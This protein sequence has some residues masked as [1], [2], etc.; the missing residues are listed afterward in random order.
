LRTTAGSALALLLAGAFAAP[1]PAA[2]L[3]APG[4][5]AAREVVAVTAGGLQ[6]GKRWAVFIASGDFAG[7][8]CRAQLASRRAHAGEPTVFSGIVPARLR[9]QL[10]PTAAQVPAPDP[11]REFVPVEPGHPYQFVV[12]I[13]D[14]MFCRKAAVARQ[15]VHAVPTGRACAPLSFTPAS[16]NG[17]FSIRARN[18]GC[19][20][21]HKAARAAEGGDL[22]YRRAGLRCRGV[23]DDSR[24]AQTIYRC[25]RRGARVTFSAS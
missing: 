6:S 11:F 3:D 19:G 24:L 14:G 8:P 10:P 17:A 2:T 12:C 13:P 25:T 5:I 1:A 20:V 7:G 18:V 22:R 21:A 4:S 16:D 23:F 9:C 15:A